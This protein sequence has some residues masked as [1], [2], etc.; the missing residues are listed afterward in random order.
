MARAPR[1]APSGGDCSLNQ[2]R[3]PLCL[4]P[5]PCLADRRL[6]GLARTPPCA[7]APCL[8]TPCE[9]RCRPVLPRP[10]MKRPPLRL[11]LTWTS[12]SALLSATRA[13]PA[14]AAPPLLLLEP[15]GARPRCAAS[16]LGCRR[17]SS[18]PLTCWRSSPHRC[19]RHPPC[20][21]DWATTPA[22]PRLPSPRG[23]T[24]ATLLPCRR[25]G[26]S[27]RASLRMRSASQRR[28]PSA[29]PPASGS[30]CGGLPAPVR[31]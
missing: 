20:R 10:V 22:P 15:T 6:L 31:A 2:A 25:P 18:S 17:P 9:C 5:C 12:A 23:R 21:R 7:G 3:L 1:R 29:P 11:C 4:P 26:T 30:G 13:L 24:L 27:A 8:L 28:R 14:A 16:H 19:R